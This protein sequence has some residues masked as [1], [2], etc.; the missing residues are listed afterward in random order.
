M[1]AIT[2]IT[3]PPSNAVPFSPLQIAPHTTLPTPCAPTSDAITTIDSASITVWFNPAR[4][5]VSAVGSSRSNSRFIGVA[6]NASEHS[7][8]SFGVFSM[9]STVMR[10]IGGSA[11]T[12]VANTP[13]VLL[14]E[15]NAIAGTR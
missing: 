13:A 7:S 10:T 4:I 6:P 11:N 12:T 3:S 2:T 1:I 9:P 14:I 5:D 15:K 8:R